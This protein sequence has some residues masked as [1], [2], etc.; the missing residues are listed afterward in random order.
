MRREIGWENVPK[1]KHIST[2]VGKCK[3]MN[4]NTF[5]WIPTLV[6]RIPYMPQTFV[7][8]FE[9]ENLFQIQPFGPLDNEFPS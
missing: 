7:T 5:K 3:D 8:W 1:F 4:V 9:G 2:S 6:V